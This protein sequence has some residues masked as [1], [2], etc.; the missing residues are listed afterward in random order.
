MYLQQAIQ[1]DSP[2]IGSRHVSVHHVITMEN[3]CQLALLVIEVMQNR[4]WN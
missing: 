1:S 3:N 2:W 4:L